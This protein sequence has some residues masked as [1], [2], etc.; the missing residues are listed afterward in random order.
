[1]CVFIRCL[2]SSQ[3]T[4]TTRLQAHHASSTGAWCL[5]V[6]FVSRAASDR[7]VAGCVGVAELNADRPQLESK[8]QAITEE[9]KKLQAVPEGKEADAAKHIEKIAELTKKSTKSI[10]AELQMTKPIIEQLEAALFEPLPPS[11]EICNAAH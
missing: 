8:L 11:L 9:I 2:Q 3:A 1:M 7:G 5:C 10:L 4:P 6:C